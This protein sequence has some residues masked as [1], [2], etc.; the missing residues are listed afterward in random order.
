MAAGSNE[1]RLVA[2]IDLS[3]V[4][5]SIRQLRS[6]IEANLSVSTLSS[7]NAGLATSVTRSNTIST[8]MTAIATNA[9]NASRESSNLSNFLGGIPGRLGAIG[10]GLV[11]IQ[12]IGN[13]FS[14]LRD[15]FGAIEDAALRLNNIAGSTE[16]ATA[17]V[18]GLSRAA[19]EAGLNFNQ[20]ASSLIALNQVTFNAGFTRQQSAELTRD[21]LRAGRALTG[22]SVQGAQGVAGNVERIISQRRLGGFE[23]RPLILS[24]VQ[25]TEIARALGV[26]PE[27]AE[28][29]L[30]SDTPIFQRGQA[31]RLAGVADVDQIQVT[32]EEFIRN[33]VRI[34]GD[35]LPDSFTTL[36]GS[37]NSLRNAL[38]EL[39]AALGRASEAFPA[40]TRIIDGLANTIGSTADSVNRREEIERLIP[41]A[42]PVRFGSNVPTLA[43][44]SP[45]AQQSNE[46]LEMA[47]QSEDQLIASISR[48]TGLS[49]QFIRDFRELFPQLAEAAEAMDMPDMTTSEALSGFTGDFRRLLDRAIE[50]IGGLPGGLSLQEYLSGLSE[51]QTRDLFNALQNQLPSGLTDEQRSIAIQDLIERFEEVRAAAEAMQA[52]IDEDLNRLRESMA[53]ESAREEGRRERNRQAEIA[54]RGVSTAIAELTTNAIRARAPIEEL[55][56]M[57]L[58]RLLQTGSNVLQS[59]LEQSLNNIFYQGSR[60]TASGGSG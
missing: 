38:G 41:D 58:D 53:E 20:I 21:V 37:S 24:G 40:L 4:T 48:T 55:L 26:R 44:P 34:V 39:G 43:S 22:T 17:R 46:R 42:L 13:T 28:R 29:L 2:S 32:F 54:I 27:I 60:P 59:S 14:Q 25:E 31:R 5:R 16:N 49:E 19:S 7:F 12:G 52:P 56:Q 33:L 23:L 35:R 15:G 8:N 6:N 9:R 57:F 47:R 3:R 50:R 11:G 1:L 10:L 51:R 36:R 18:R 45:Q 30:S